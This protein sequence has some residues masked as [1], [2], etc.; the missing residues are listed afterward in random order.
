MS[1]ELDVIVLNENHRRKKIDKLTKSMNK[2]K[3][4][5]E[6]NKQ[7]V[8]RLNLIELEGKV[9]IKK[10][11][12]TVLLKNITNNDRQIKLL[13]QN[14]ENQNITNNKRQI[15]LLQQNNR[16]NSSKIDNLITELSRLELERYD[17][18]LE[19]I[20]LTN[21]MTENEKVI[22]LFEGE[23]KQLNENF[24]KKLDV[25]QTPTNSPTRVRS[26]N[27]SN[28]PKITRWPIT[29]R[30][31]PTLL[32]KSNSPKKTNALQDKTK[33][34]LLAKKSVP[35]LMPRKPMPI[36]HTITN[37]PTKVSSPKLPSSNRSN[38]PNRSNSPKTTRRPITRRAHPTLVIKS[39]SPENTNAFQDKTKKSLAKSTRLLT[40]PRK[41]KP[42]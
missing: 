17:K 25:P 26:P 9:Q 31:Q 30:A 14:N 37:F 10:H 6:I 42:K 2:L 23:I 21:K 15:K 40:R 4:E 8:E 12:R 3:Q 1:N 18:H 19:Y 27:R 35:Q 24:R 13:Q 33:K 32:K 41:P 7:K 39:K 11:R 36:I 28:S 29:R 22:K 34:F 16:T 38:L 20:I 5:N